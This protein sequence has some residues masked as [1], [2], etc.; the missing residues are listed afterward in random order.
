V[1]CFAGNGIL[2]GWIPFSPAV[3]DPVTSG[4]LFAVFPAV[5]Q[6]SGVLQHAGCGVAAGA[7][8]KTETS[9]LVLIPFSVPID[10][11]WWFL[12]SNHGYPRCAIMYALCSLDLL[13][14]RRH[15]DSYL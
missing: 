10:R 11:L 1:G 9:F 13:Y 5:F 6:G 4:S 7:V 12:Y 2:P 3:A 14:V 8:S 15:S